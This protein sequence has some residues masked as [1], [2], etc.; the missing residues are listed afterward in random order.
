MESRELRTSLY[1]VGEGAPVNDVIAPIVK[2]DGD[3]EEPCWIDVE[4]GMTLIPW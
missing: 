1:V 2:Y 4:R 3:Q